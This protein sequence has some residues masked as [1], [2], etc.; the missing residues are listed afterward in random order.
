[1]EGKMKHDAIGSPRID[2][3]VVS[4]C[5][6]DTLRGCIAPLAGLPDVQVIVV[7]NASPDDS[8]AT[9]AD[10]PVTTV[11]A[12]RNGGFAYGCNL[13][14]SHGR[15][16]YVLFLNP[17]ARLHKAD[18]DVLAGVLESDPSAGLVGPRILDDAGTV[19]ESQR[20]FPDVLTAWGQA[21][22]VHRLIARTHEMIEGAAEYERA[23]EPDWISGACMLGRRADFERIG[24]MDEA[25]FLYSEDTDICKQI[26]DLGM[27]VRYEPRAVAHHTGG[28][29][30]P[31]STLLPVLAR[32]R[33]Q[34]AFKHGSR[35]SAVVQAVGI[36]VGEATHALVRL[37]R[38]RY[39]RGH[40]A[41]FAEV[42]RCLRAPGAPAGQSPA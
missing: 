36:A 27:T 4:Y 19:M 3:V 11:A 22:F 31:R 42:L 13:G 37:G 35:L 1:V 18:L 16:P 7:D 21:L 8:L 33:V 34:Y 6:S 26:R 39:A 17:D 9:I 30:A 38:G 29:S 40:A 23:G 20:R 10:L 25:F 14:M 5:S 32:S 41:A 2:V 12:P 28:A 24:G 15:A